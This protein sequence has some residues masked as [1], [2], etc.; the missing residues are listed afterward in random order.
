MSKSFSLR[1]QRIELRTKPEIKAIIE[2]AAQLRHTT[3]SAFMLESALQ[4]ARA[5]LMDAESLLLNEGDRD[6]FF[7]ALASPPEP[8]ESLRKL[9]QDNPG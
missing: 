8:N 1:S 5:E 2:R 7:N 3:V 9:F 6:R 4:Q